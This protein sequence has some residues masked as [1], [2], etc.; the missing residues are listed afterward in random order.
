MRSGERLSAPRDKTDRIRAA[1]VSGGMTD[2]F[3]TVRRRPQS[4]LRGVFVGGGGP[5]GVGVPEVPRVS[6]GHDI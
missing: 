4:A 2:A 1:V 5:P 6:S 3:D